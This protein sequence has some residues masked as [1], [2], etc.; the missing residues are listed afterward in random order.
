MARLSSFGIFLLF[1]APGLGLTGHLPQVVHFSKLDYR[2]QNQNWDISQGPGQKMYV[3]NTGGLLQYDGARWRH[4]PLP[5]S[6][7]VRSNYCSSDGKIFIGG[8]A[9]VGY[10]QAGNDGRFHYHSLADQIEEEEIARKEIWHFLPS[11]YGLFFQSFSAVFRYEGGVVEKLATPGNAMFMRE[12]NG[13]L[14]LPV[15]HKGLFEY[16]PGGEFRKVPGGEALAGKRVAAILPF[17]ASSF[18]ACTE[19]SG[20]FLFSEEGVRQWEAPVCA[21]LQAA[22]LNKGIRLKDGR[23]AFGTILNGLFITD[24]RGN[25]LF[26]INQENGLQNNTVLSLFEDK[27]HNLWAGLDR[28]I[29]LLG[30]RSPLSFYPDKGGGIGTVYTAKIYQGRLYLG[31]N[32]GI[33]YKSWPSRAGED[34]QLVENSQGQ[35]WSL[36][37]LQGQLLCAHNTGV[38]A[39]RE[40]KVASLYNATGVYKVLPFPQRDDILLLCTYRGLSVLQ[41]NAA[42]SWQFRNDLQGFSLQAKEAAFDSRGRL[43]AA[44]PH[45]GVFCLQADK[46]LARVEVLDVPVFGALPP[47][48]TLKAQLRKADEAIFLITDSLTLR[49]EEEEGRLVPGLPAAP[50]G[51]LSQPDKWVAGTGGDW[52]RILPS[53]VELFHDE[54]IIRLEARLNPANEDIAILTDST[55]LFYTEEGYAILQKGLL[56]EKENTFLPS[57]MISALSVGNRGAGLLQAESLPQPLSLRA[58]EN[59]LHFFFSAPHYVANVKMRY[60]LIGFEDEWSPFQQLYDKEYNNL[61]SGKYTFQVQSELSPRKTAAFTFTIAP[62]WYQAIWAKLG[63]AALILL[64]IWAL[65]KAHLY[66][67]RLQKRKLKLEKAKELHQQRIRTKNEMLQAEIINKSRKLADSTMELVRKNEMLIKLKEDLDRY[68]KKQA[69]GSARQDLE[70]MARR[71]DR[72]LSSEEDWEAIKDNF[73]QLHDQFFK[74]LKDEYPELTPGD[75][76]LAAY[77]K[78]NLAS[79]EIAPLLNISLRGVENK[80]YRLRRKLQLEPDVNLTEFILQY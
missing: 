43:W 76:R 9:T 20:I 56:D 32:Q 64:A 6:P 1:L 44:H 14:F 36:Q 79:K 75:L 74:R 78:M 30:L 34:F 25:V 13:R 61:P 77:L 11:R 12:V 63:A 55:Y 3:S 58:T 70:K 51:F 59:E 80:R 8:Y 66:R 49:W 40:D 27:A 15:I 53:H 38:F 2:A 71:I 39:I 10:W 42:G 31:T 37:V 16:L 67:L 73:N 19:K 29:D 24:E 7:M 33:Y 65:W 41:K 60:R 45:R 72:H 28:G 54:H 22:Q 52:F 4:F 62:Q 50:A 5:N 18:L 68:R 26:H 47:L 35:A 57:P 46:K 17:G 23:F 48:F 21:G 69:P